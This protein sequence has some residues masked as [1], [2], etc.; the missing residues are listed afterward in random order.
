M[1]EREIQSL[2]KDNTEITV[3]KVRTVYRPCK[4]QYPCEELLKNKQNLLSYFATE[5]E[6]NIPSNKMFNLKS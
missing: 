4:Y 2:S 5:F 6:S 3:V 1:G